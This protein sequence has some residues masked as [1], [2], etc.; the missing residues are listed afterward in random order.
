MNIERYIMPVIVA[1]GI[2]G[3]LLLSFIDPVVMYPARK[4]KDGPREPLPIVDRIEIIPETSATGAAGEK[5]GGPEPLPSIPDLPR[6]LPKE[7][8]FTAQVT[9]TVVPLKPITALL[10]IPEGIGEPGD[11]TGL[12]KGPPGVTSYTNLDRVPRATVRPAPNYPD[13]MRK[14]AT[15]GAV[16]VEFVVDTTGRVVSAEAVRWTHRD[17]VDPAVRAVLRWRF[18][19]GTMNGRKVSFRMAVPIEFYAAL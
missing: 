19:P 1:A 11:G 14:S 12:R 13:T 16:T 18:E 8:S 4:T 15:D 10:K 17:F 2:H 5:S 7:V 3:A 9:D 6:E